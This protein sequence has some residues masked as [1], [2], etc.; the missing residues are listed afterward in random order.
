[1]EREELKRI[2]E[3][4]I[5]SFSRTE[6]TCCGTVP[7]G[8]KWKCVTCYQYDFCA[9]CYTRRRGSHDAQHK[10]IKVIANK[11]PGKPCETMR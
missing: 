5:H 6:C 2:L 8:I 3:E 11:P 9:L 1:M 4:K 10:F 7:A